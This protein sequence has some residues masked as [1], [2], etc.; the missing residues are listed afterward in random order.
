MSF[1]EDVNFL[2]GINMMCRPGALYTGHILQ[3]SLKLKKKKM[4]RKL[5]S[6]KERRSL[7]NTG[8]QLRRAQR[9]AL[10]DLASYSR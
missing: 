9:G 8:V 5:K 1:R 3:L 2:I 10:T 7:I 4:T 6:D